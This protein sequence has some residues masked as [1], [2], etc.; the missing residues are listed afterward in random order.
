VVNA[1]LPREIRGGGGA[2]ERP[3]PWRGALQKG[4]NTVSF[5]N[6]RKPDSGAHWRNLEFERLIKR[7]LELTF[8][9][10]ADEYGRA[11]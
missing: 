11:A 9:H 6:P 5:D 8:R 4:S 7:F 3:H 10:I 2:A 1:V